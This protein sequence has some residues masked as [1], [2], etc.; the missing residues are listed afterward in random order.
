MDFGG[1]DHME[2]WSY[3]TFYA[4]WFRMCIF[5]CFRYANHM[6]ISCY[7]K[8]SFSRFSSLQLS[9]IS[10]IAP[11]D[12][13]TIIKS[14]TLTLFQLPI[15]AL[16]LHHIN[17]VEIFCGIWRSHKLGNL[18]Y[19]QMRSYI[20]LMPTNNGTVYSPYAKIPPPPP[21]HTHARTHYHHHHPHPLPFP[22]WSPSDPRGYVMEELSA[23]VSLSPGDN[24]LEPLHKGP[25][26][27]VLIFSFMI[28]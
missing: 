27:Q 8:I 22:Y 9:L 13:E 3:F 24:Q 7:A 18:S 20:K 28:V 14:F 25:I 4:K 6:L 16:G 12:S 17:L 15:L 10:F 21:P 19:I 26:T 5:F 11:I 23:L 1:Q 2:K